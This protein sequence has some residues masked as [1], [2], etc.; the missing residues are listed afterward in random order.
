M[1]LLGSAAVALPEVIPGAS[2]TVSAAE[3]Y[4][5]FE[6]ETLEDGTVKITRYKGTASVLTVPS[7]IKGKTVSVI[8][9][10]SFRDC[11]QLTKVIVPNGVTSIGSWAFGECRRLA[12]VTISQSVTDIDTHAFQSCN[13]LENI[14][15]SKYN[16]AYCSVDGALLSKDKKRLV[17][18]PGGKEGEYNIPSG[19]V[20]TGEYAFLDSKLNYVGI[21]ESVTQ[22][23]EHAFAYSLLE[24]VLIPGSVE[25]IG[26]DAFRG[27]YSLV[28][29][30]MSEGIK[31]I[32]EDVF[33]DCQRISSVSVPGSVEQ[34]G[35]KCFCGCV[36]LTEI[37]VNGSNDNYCSE[38]GVLFNKNKTTLICC[39]G[40]KEGNYSIP[41][42]VTRIE[43][44]A[45]YLC[46]DLT[47]VNIPESVTAVGTE[48]FA[49]CVRLESVNLPDSMT[50]VGDYMFNGCRRLTSVTIPDSV[51]TIGRN[52]FISCERL[53][54][55]IPDSV[56]T[57]KMAAFVGCDNLTSV[58]IPDSVTT[59]EQGAFASCRNLTSVNIP[60][61]VTE[62][63]DFLFYHCEKLTSVNIPDSVKRI[64][65]MAFYACGNLTSVVI[66]RYVTEISERAF[67]DCPD[68]TI[69]GVKGSYAETYAK[70]N[71]IPFRSVFSNTSSLS[72][73][74]IK[75]GSTVN[76][77]CAARD[78]KNDVT[79]KVLYRL[80]D[81]NY[82]TRLQDFS[83]ETTVSFKPKAAVKY[84][85]RV[86]AKDST[87]RVVAKDMNLDV[88]RTLTNTS[89][90]SADTIKKGEKVTIKCSSDGGQT[91][92]EYAAFYK[93]A[94]SGS[95]T[96]LQGFS[97]S[98]SVVF[99]PKY[100][101]K[102]IIR[103]KVR[104][105]RGYVITKD[106]EL[107]VKR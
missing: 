52:A 25:S 68:L 58:T 17:C 77:Q 45:F 85:I 19:V 40:G 33:M 90:L 39:P 16:N 50:Y 35:H 9:D 56:N 73:S 83:A 59:I 100:G 27:C 4:G 86:I 106:M 43:D 46:Q 75:L 13:M 82:W 32:D 29:V 76:I 15:V 20:T 95:W 30:T 71:N 1:L 26:R 60:D 102:Y 67:G 99:T 8:G 69:S 14:N 55:N 87:G 38:D 12:S 51:T 65:D 103:T 72:A 47:A 70:N 37:N 53:S 105:A 88:F 24:S 61:G 66:P 5:N 96:K 84:V 41:D 44:K 18:F 28:Y 74:S 94:D 64:G 2:V 62:L 80:K 81:K 107:T 49:Y 54:V 63:G 92:V 23:E 57:I 89:S 22:I 42:S 34:I 104:D 6:Y 79:Y 11:Y 97:S 3:T 36:S 10:Y 98:K 93:P 48:I 7:T 101:V 78:H 31:M 21:P 91:P